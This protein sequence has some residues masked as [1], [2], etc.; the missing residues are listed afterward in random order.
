MN[1]LNRSRREMRTQRGVLLTPQRQWHSLLF[2]YWPLECILGHR[3]SLEAWRYVMSSIVSGLFFWTAFQPARFNLPQ[4]CIHFGEK[5]TPRSHR[6][7]KGPNRGSL[8]VPVSGHLNCI[9]CSER[10]LVDAWTCVGLQV[11]GVCVCAGHH[12]LNHA[13]WLKYKF[14]LSFALLLN[15]NCRANGKYV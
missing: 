15:I 14:Y 13:S 11:E 5:P 7:W 12:S 6:R 1:S 10:T 3:L 4:P 2:M 8:R 9:S